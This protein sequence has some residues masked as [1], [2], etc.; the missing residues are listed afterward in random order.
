MA[1]NNKQREDCSNTATIKIHQKT[2]GNLPECLEV[3]RTCSV[4]SFFFSRI[5]Y[6]RTRQIKNHTHLT[7]MYKKLEVK[8]NL[9]CNHLNPDTWIYLTCTT[10]IL[11]KI[12]LEN[13]FVIIIELTSTSLESFKNVSLILAKK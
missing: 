12:L 6:S 10:Y 11:L 5:S 2:L 8:Y 7:Y 3:A 1:L 4:L 13:R 9:L